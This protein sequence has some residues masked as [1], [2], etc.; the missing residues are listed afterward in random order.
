[1]AMTSA[2]ASCELSFVHAKDFLKLPVT[3]PGLDGQAA[4]GR[5]C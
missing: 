3:W 2:S 1:L 4:R 5:D